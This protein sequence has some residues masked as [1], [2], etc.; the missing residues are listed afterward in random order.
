MVV[1]VTITENTLDAVGFFFSQV[2]AGTEIS[3][4]CV[5]VF[6]IS[7]I[8]EYLFWSG[9]FEFDS[10]MIQKFYLVNFF[11]LL[12]KFENNEEQQRFYLILYISVMFE[13]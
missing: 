4:V 10:D 5:H 13:E 12:T 3:S 2:L 1:M 8:A 7:Y 9:R 6:G 11:I